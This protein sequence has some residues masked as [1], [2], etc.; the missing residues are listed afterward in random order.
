MLD[1]NTIARDAGMNFPDKPEADYESK[2]KQF[3]SEADKSFDK[4]FVRH[5]VDSHMKGVDLFT[6]ASKELKN[7]QLRSFAEKTLP[8]IKEHL[9]TAKRLEGEVGRE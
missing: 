3:R 6:R 5:M 1:E 2:V 7:V 8:T 9:T 4:D